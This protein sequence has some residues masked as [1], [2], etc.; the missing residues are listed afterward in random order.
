MSA[1]NR[2]ESL[3]EE[4]KAV[5][6]GQI[7]PQQYQTWVSTLVPDDETVSQGVLALK[8]PNTFFRDWVTRRYGRM[9][10][11]A[12]Q[13]ISG[14]QLK[15]IRVTEQDSGKGMLP[16]TEMVDVTHQAPTS[17][18]AAK[19]QQTILNPEF[20]FKNFA[21]GGTNRLA[22]AAAE[23]L[24][25][26][27]VAP[28]SA[29]YLHGGVGVGKSHLL[30]A[31]C[32]AKL[33]AKPGFQIRYVTGEQFANGFIAALDSGK[34]SDFRAGFRLV[35]LLV[36]DD[37]HFLA[38]K[39]KI[40]DEFLHTFSEIRDRRRLVAV[41]APQV[42]SQLE[43]MSP[44]L[45]SLLVSGMVCEVGAPDQQVRAAIMGR[46][47]ESLGAR[48]DDDVLTFLVQH[49]SGNGRELEGA[50]TRLVFHQEVLGEKLDLPRVRLILEDLL[51]VH[52]RE[53]SLDEIV[54]HVRH[55]YRVGRSDLLGPRR[56]QSIARPRQVAMYIARVLTT[57]SLHDIG[58]YFGRRDH[59]TVLYSVEKI[60]SL[61]AE[62]PALK[63]QVQRIIAGLRDP[64]IS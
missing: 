14:G 50:A 51:E 20:T 18:P 46:R 43:G 53:Y 35:D 33:V 30:Q 55:E 32:A 39:D 23:H 37:V 29:L 16:M 27:E 9:I 2:S 49:I 63:D 3:W 6:Q 48:L 57:L 40:Q 15:G 61:T 64:Q 59:T 1:D 54:E 25:E 7:S 41:A 8:A 38:G 58:R 13:E 28:Y 26:R 10:E 22:A 60:E 11:R 4:V 31:L 45:V 44:R 21:I 62:D 56:T 24:A 12:V 42:P 19:Q 5:L 52:Y 36:V 17:S 34:I 47:L